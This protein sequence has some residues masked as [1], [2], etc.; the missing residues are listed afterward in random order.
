VLFFRLRI[1]ESEQYCA[2]AVP[3]LNGV[4]RLN[5]AE[6]ANMVLTLLL[7][8]VAVIPLVLFGMRNEPHPNRLKL[9][10]LSVLV[11]VS[12]IFATSANYIFSIEQPEELYWN[13]FGKLACIV[14]IA[15]LFVILPTGTLQKSGILRLPS[16][17]SAL[18]IFMVAILCA[19]LG[20]AAGPANG[21]VTVESLAYQSTM[22]SLAEEP[23][24]RAMLPALLA[25]ALGSPWKLVGAQL[26]WW[27]LVCA[28]LD[29]AGHGLFWT[30]QGGP[31]FHA[32]SF[33]A[34]IIFG[35]LFGWLAA[36]CHSVW[37][38]VICHSL[39]NATGLAIALISG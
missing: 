39:I 31:E 9:L 38:C 18:P 2:L 19:L 32:I 7:W 6:A 33:V 26:G 16:K 35:L 34:S 1:L 11:L 4:T 23:V 30:L 15:F 13:W 10:G 25:A 22:P 8:L 37:P 21:R 36:R 14:V 28:F 20:A 29:G 5:T 27:W 24:L 3:L 17:S 12:T